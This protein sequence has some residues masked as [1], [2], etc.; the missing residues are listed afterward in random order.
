LGFGVFCWLH[1][2]S[3][4]VFLPFLLPGKVWGA[5]VLILL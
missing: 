5:L 1:R 2:M 3:L 4:I